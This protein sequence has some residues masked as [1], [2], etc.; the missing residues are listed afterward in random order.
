VIELLR[1]TAS[2]FP[3]VALLSVP[4]AVS[5]KSPGRPEQLGPVVLSFCFQNDTRICRARVWDDAVSGGFALVF[6]LRMV[7]L[8]VI[9][10]RSISRPTHVSATLT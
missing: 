9:N 6:A 1:T 2:T 7:C 10:A 5:A 3:W 4:R 8:L